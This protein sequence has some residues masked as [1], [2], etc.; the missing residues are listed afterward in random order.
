MTGGCDGEGVV[1]LNNRLNK[2]IGFTVSGSFGSILLLDAQLATHAR[3][4]RRAANRC[5][6]LE[7]ND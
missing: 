4:L 3:I 5:Q 7:T 2:D 6:V 1:F